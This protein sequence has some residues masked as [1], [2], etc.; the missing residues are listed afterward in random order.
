MEK[1]INKRIENYLSEFKET[2]KQK[3]NDLGVSSDDNLSQL[4][5]F[6]YDY[7]R[8][9]L[10]KEDFMKR[11]RVKNVVH[12]A[13]R[14]CAKRAN[15]ETRMQH[16]DLMIYYEIGLRAFT[17][18]GLGTFVGFGLCALAILFALAV[19]MFCPTNEGGDDDR[20]DL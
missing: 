6:I 14:C 5:Q 10:T 7:E 4:V 12:L 15:G 19:S 3:A 16:S 9:C 11:K 20:V 13:D 1:R 2:V 17:G 8:L 18:F